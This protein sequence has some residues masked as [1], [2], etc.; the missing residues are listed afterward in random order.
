VV[1]LPSSHSFRPPPSCLF[2]FAAR[3]P[4]V[5]QP[6]P[7]MVFSLSLAVDPCYVINEYTFSYFS[8][9]LSSIV[10]DGESILAGFV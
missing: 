7:V 10:V 5:T 3:V 6:L 1:F 4:F 2:F 9:G 8:L